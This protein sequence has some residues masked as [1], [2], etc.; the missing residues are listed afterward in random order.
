MNERWD[1]LF[2][3]ADDFPL[4]GLCAQE[5]PL[6]IRF[7]VL[8][9]FQGNANKKSTRTWHWGTAFALLAG[10]SDYTWNLS[11]LASDDWK[12]AS[13]ADW[14]ERQRRQYQK[15]VVIHKLY[16]G[17]Y[18][19]IPITYVIGMRH[20]L[21]PATSFMLTVCSRTHQATL[22]IKSTK[23]IQFLPCITRLNVRSAMQA[24]W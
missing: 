11:K 16:D 5:G 19:V 7:E 24:M 10:R 2:D 12:N 8:R 22:P 15:S 17:W 6:Q 21:L 4:A 14:V 9:S 18:K 23:V 1:P 13:L 3:K 20:T